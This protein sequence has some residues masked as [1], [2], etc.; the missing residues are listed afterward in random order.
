MAINEV[1]VAFLSETGYLFPTRAP[2]QLIKRKQ[3]KLVSN[4]PV[5]TGAFQSIF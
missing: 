4:T 1:L 5:T 2:S 3:A